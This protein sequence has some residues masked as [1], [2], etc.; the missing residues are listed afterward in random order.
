[1][2]KPYPN[3]NFQ[4]FIIENLKSVFPNK[5]ISTYNETVK[6]SKHSFIPLFNN[7]YNSVFIYQ[8]TTEFRIINKNNIKK[9]KLGFNKRGF[10]I[11]DDNYCS[12]EEDINYTQ[13]LSGLISEN[14]SILSHID[15]EP[16]C[17]CCG[18]S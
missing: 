4:N 11:L 9:I 16:C 18:I 7:N 1:M 6:S 13:G 12:V 5:T 2:V 10:Q 15:D 17:C 3:N 8:D 14:S